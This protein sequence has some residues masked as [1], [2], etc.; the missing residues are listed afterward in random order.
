MGQPSIVVVSDSMLVRFLNNGQLLD[1][2]NDHELSMRIWELDLGSGSAQ[3]E[4]CEVLH[5]MYVTVSEFGEYP[6]QKVFVLGP[7]YDS[8]FENWI[9]E[10][11]E[12]AGF[13]MNHLGEGRR[14]S[15]TYLL[16]REEKIIRRSH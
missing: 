4:S 9:I 5:H 11:S 7:F 1:S 2:N 14:E 15:I 6:E 10:N 12:L 8:K 3:T 16:D 13:R